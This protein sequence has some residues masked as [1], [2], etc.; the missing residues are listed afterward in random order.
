MD[1]QQEVSRLQQELWAA[2][3]YVDA[4]TNGQ[5]ERFAAKQLAEWALVRAANE[6]DGR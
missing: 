5:G 3:R 1:A 6:R 2:R 4:V